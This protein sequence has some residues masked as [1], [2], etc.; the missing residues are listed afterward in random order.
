MAVTPKSPDATTQP[1]TSPASDAAKPV[2]DV[3]KEKHSRAFSFVSMLFLVM[4]LVAGIMSYLWYGQSQQA[5]GYQNDIS[6]LRKETESLRTTIAALKK[7]NANLGDAVVDQ[8]ANGTATQTDDEA[9]RAVVGARVHAYKDGADDK[10][11]ITY[12][13][14]EVPFARVGVS[15]EPAGGYACWLKKAD[16]I[17]L[18]LFCGQAPPLQAELDIWGVPSSILN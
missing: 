17:W 7:Q 6:S 8:V 1:S 4:L 15:V 9:I 13:K 10:F 14:K 5:S 2:L 16:D 3:P 12:V 11:T 18:V